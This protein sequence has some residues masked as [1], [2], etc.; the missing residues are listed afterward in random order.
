MRAPGYSEPELQN[1][2]AVFDGNFLAP[3]GSF[4]GYGLLP[5]R[6]NFAQ[7]VLGAGIIEAFGKVGAGHIA[8]GQLDH[9]AIEEPTGIDLVLE[10]F[11]IAEGLPI[12]MTEAPIPRAILLA[13]A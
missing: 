2:A 10:Q 4:P 8:I 9:I 5:E 12:R 1:E 6:A 11:R 13:F 7:A 3:N